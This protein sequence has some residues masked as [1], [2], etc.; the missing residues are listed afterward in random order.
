M[1]SSWSGEA[2]TG[3]DAIARLT[4]PPDLALLSVNLPGGD[5]PDRDHHHQGTGS[6]VPRDRADRRTRPGHPPSGHRVRGGRLS[7]RRKVRCPPCVLD[8]IGARGRHPRATQH[9]RTAARGHL[10]AATGAGE[11]VRLLARPSRREQEGLRIRSTAPATRRSGGLSLISPQT[12][13]THIQRVIR[14]LGVH[15]RLEAAMLATQ[16]GIVDELRG[17]TRNRP[18]IRTRREPQRLIGAIACPL[19]NRSIS[20]TVSLPPRR[21]VEGSAYPS[22]THRPLGRGTRMG[23]DAAGTLALLGTP[24]RYYAALRMPSGTGS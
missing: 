3:S 14:K 11:L 7:R 4:N 15:S 13:R 9:A 5:W 1:T 6:H 22:P 8:P 18:R 10:L 2:L 19:L 17:V 16:S 24:Y 23:S 21:A 20:G 12:A